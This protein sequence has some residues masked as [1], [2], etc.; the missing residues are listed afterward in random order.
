MRDTKKLDQKI[1][2]ILVPAILENAFLILSDM[3]LTGYIGRLSVT[4]ISAYGISTRVYGIYFSILK[5]FAIGTMVIFARAFGAG[6]R[7]EGLNYYFQALF[8][9]FPIALVAAVLIWVFPQLLLST[10]SSDATLLTYG[11]SFLRIHVLTYPLLAVIHLNSSMFQADGNTKTPLYIATIGN[12]VSMVLGYVFILGI[13]PIQGMGLQGAAITNNLRII[14]MLLVGV[15]LL[16]NRNSVY[17][18]HELSKFN[19][20]METIKELIRFGLPTAIGNSFWNFAA[21][22]LSTYILS[23]GQQFYAA[24]QIGL[25]AEGFCDMMSAGFLTAAMS[26]SSLAIGA[27]DA[28]MFKTSYKRLNYYCYIICGINMLFLLLFSK[29]VL[30]LLTDKMELIDIAHV[31]LLS[32]I[33]SQ[34]PQMKSKIEYGYIRSVGFSTLPTI[35]DM[36]GI[37]GVRVFGCYVVS[38]VFHLDI[39]WIWMI[40]NADQWVRYLLS[41]GV[42]ISKKVLRYLDQ[43]H[44]PFQCEGQVNA[45]K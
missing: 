45:C 6:K 3:I 32:M 41:A 30:H 21:V 5:G 7:K 34:F 13:G 10:M 17:R 16:F 4:E 1:L 44:F 26:L 36:V 40:V 20:D 22:F 15:Y 33:A 11:A 19:I 38:S 43:P 23:Y 27:K 39:F 31:Y 35:I 8:I 42:I 9:A 14:V 37:W 18:S 29:N 25:Q 24:Y 12:L 2:R 28:D